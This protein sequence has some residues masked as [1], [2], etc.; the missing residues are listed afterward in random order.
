MPGTSGEQRIL[1]IV[2]RPQHYWYGTNFRHGYI[3]RRS[4]DPLE[5]TS[6]ALYALSVALV[7]GLG[8]WLLRAGV[9]TVGTIY[10]VYSYN[11][12]LTSKLRSA[13]QYSSSS[14]ETAVRLPWK[15]S[16]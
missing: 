13:S 16:I 3:G 12:L 11:D 7:F 15:T 8:A 14:T 4:E 6:V 10:V 5:P 9:I 1:T 2:V